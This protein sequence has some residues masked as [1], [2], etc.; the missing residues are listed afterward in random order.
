[1]SE[2]N[3]V[4]ALTDEILRVTE[5]RE[6]YLALPN[7]VGMMAAIVMQAAINIAKE[8]QA[9]GDILQMIPALRNLQEFEL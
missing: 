1:M 5:I 2:Q 6:Q 4:G 3:L 9:S 8:A 7:G